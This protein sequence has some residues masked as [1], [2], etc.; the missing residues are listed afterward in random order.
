MDQQ[1]NVRSRRKHHTVRHKRRDFAS[2]ATKS[3][4]L[5]NALI[6]IIFEKKNTVWDD[7]GVKHF[8][9]LSE[10]IYSKFILRWYISN[11]K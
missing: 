3:A 1:T 10:M 9:T 7:N 5:K 11:L 6:K 4:K 2:T 8:V